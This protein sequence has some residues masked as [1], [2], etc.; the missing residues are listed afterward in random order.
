ML[1]SVLQQFK[2]I[3]CIHMVLWI[4]GF[5]SNDLLNG[6]HLCKWEYRIC[7]LLYLPFKNVTQDSILELSPQGYVW[8]PQC[9]WWTHSIID[10]KNTLLFP[11][12]NIF[13]LKWYAAITERSQELQWLNLWI[14][15]EFLQCRVFIY[16]YTQ[17]CSEARTGQVREMQ[18]FYAIYHHCFG[19]RYC[20]LDVQSP[21]S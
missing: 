5:L 2:N 12:K 13:F 21:F 16:S 3:G 17:R 18:Q 4:S 8:V 6:N 7:E 19:N 11:A 9:F 15:I 20:V 1:L 10:K 14:C